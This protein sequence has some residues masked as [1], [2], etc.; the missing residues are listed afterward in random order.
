MKARFVS[1]PGSLNRTLKANHL[2]AWSGKPPPGLTLLGVSVAISESGVTP[3]D[4]KQ[5]HELEIIEPVT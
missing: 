4:T 3:S 2:W 1:I 5:L